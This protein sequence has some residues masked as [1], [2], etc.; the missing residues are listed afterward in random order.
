[1]C[2]SPV[3]GK[4]ARGSAFGNPGRQVTTM[5]EGTA[6]GLGLSR[7]KPRPNGGVAGAVWRRG[8]GAAPSPD[9]GLRWARGG[10]T[11]QAD[12]AFRAN[13]RRAPRRQP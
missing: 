4:V 8:R 6:N 10:P 5:S 7:S 1:M 9:G 12:P 13:G 3:T 11:A 2:Q